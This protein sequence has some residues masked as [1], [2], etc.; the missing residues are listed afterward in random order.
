MKTRLVR[1]YLT[2][3]RKNLLINMVQLGITRIRLQK[4]VEIV[5]YALF[6]GGFVFGR[7]DLKV[8]LIF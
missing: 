6:E 1:A 7:I 2:E 4:Y 8:K 5:E 3:W